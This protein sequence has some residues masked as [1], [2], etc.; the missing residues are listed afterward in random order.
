MEVKLDQFLLMHEHH[1]RKCFLYHH[2]PRSKEKRWKLGAGKP[3]V[4]KKGAVPIPTVPKWVWKT[5]FKKVGNF[6]TIFDFLWFL[7][8]MTVKRNCLC[9]NGHPVWFFARSFLEQ[10]HLANLQ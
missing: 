7:V 6:S 4:R 8:C 1:P 5:V 3:L 10:Q 2:P 9:M